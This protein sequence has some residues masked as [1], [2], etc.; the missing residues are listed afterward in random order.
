MYVDLSSTELRDK[1][2]NHHGDPIHIV[3]KVV[4]SGSIRNRV[5]V[6]GKKYGACACKGQGQ[7][8]WKIRA[9]VVDRGPK[10]G[11]GCQR[12]LHRV[13]DRASW[14][15]QRR[16]GGPQ[17]IASSYSTSNHQSLYITPSPNIVLQPHPR[18]KAM[19]L[20]FPNHQNVPDFLFT[21]AP[22]SNCF[23]TNTQQLL[24]TF[25]KSVYKQ[26]L[27]CLPLFGVV[28]FDEA[29]CKDSLTEINTNKLIVLK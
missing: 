17:P 9:E 12:D 10:F 5:R 8:P 23:V 29:S 6:L 22:I 14:H 20:I 19:Y 21:E 3:H 15:V 4:H 16:V 1:S 25:I 2:Q 24:F 26:Y 11:V 27:Q 28:T 13:C 7:G 18:R